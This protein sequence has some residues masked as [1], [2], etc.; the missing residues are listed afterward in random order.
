[1]CA[2]VHTH[3]HTRTHT[4]RRADHNN[5]RSWKA[6][7]GMV[8]DLA[9]PRKKNFKPTVKKTE[10][11]LDVCLRILKELE[12]SRTSGARGKGVAGIRRV[13]LKEPKK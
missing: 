10:N 9:D 13:N 12:A 1:M 8:T 3:T 6:D 4:P 11:Q 5:V 7:G 2:H